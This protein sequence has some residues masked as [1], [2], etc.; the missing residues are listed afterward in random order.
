[1]RQVIERYKPLVGLH[2]HIHES[3]GIQKLGRTTCVNPG[4]EYTEG[5]LPSAVIDFTKKGECGT[6]SLS[7]RDVVLDIR[8]RIARQ[9]QST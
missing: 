3:R 5:L 2:G 7:S 1:M 4:S 8:R 9:A 6:L